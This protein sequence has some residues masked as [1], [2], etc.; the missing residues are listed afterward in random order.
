MIRAIVSFTF[1]V[2]FTYLLVS[3]CCPD[4]GP[5]LIPPLVAE[6]V[7][8][9]ATAMAN[10]ESAIK[11]GQIP[12]TWSSQNRIVQ[13]RMAHTMYG[14]QAFSLFNSWAVLFFVLKNTS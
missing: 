2:S 11:A 8:E 13:N 14:L 1:I 12:E 4:L 6:A 3:H 5:F 9:E 7:Q 10:L